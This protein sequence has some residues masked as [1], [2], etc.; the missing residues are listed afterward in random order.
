MR[1]DTNYVGYAGVI[2]RKHQWPGQLFQKARDEVAMLRQLHWRDQC[3]WRHDS[4]DVCAKLT[5]SH[6]GR[7][8]KVGRE[9]GNSCVSLHPYSILTAYWDSRLLRYCFVKD[10]SAHLD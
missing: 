5:V 4:S 2:Y 8:P 6:S 7:I 9:D 1:A 3:T 10:V